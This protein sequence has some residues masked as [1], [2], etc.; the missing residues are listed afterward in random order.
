MARVVLI[1]SF[2]ADSD[3]VQNLTVQASPHD[4]T[5]TL[6]IRHIPGRNDSMHELTDFSD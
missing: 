5:L 2:A 4:C 6:N 3:G 1:A